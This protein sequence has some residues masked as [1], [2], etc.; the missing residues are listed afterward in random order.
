MR[1]QI[2]L[3]LIAIALASIFLSA[4]VLAD[5]LNRPADTL[6]AHDSAHVYGITPGETEWEI[7]T[8]QERF[9]SCVV[10]E[11]EVRCMT[12]E[13]LLETVLNYPYLVNIY[14]YDSLSSGIEAVSEYF[15]GLQEFINRDDALNTLANFLNNHTGYCTAS[16]TSEGA[17]QQLCASD[18]KAYIDTFTE[19]THNVSPL[20]IVVSTIRTPK[21]SPV[22]VFVG[23]TWADHQTSAT[24]QYT[25]QQQYLLTYPSIE[26]VSGV[27][28][29]Y[30]CH[31]Y[32]FYSTSSSNNY[33]MNDPSPYLE[34]GS[35]VHTTSTTVGNRVVYFDANDTP[36][37]SAIITTSGM[38][39]ILTSKWGCNAVFRHT[40]LDCPYVFS[41]GGYN[42]WRAS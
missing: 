12:T 8:T 42:Y 20:A 11:E 30:N 35:Y 10:T 27:D 17:F 18:L 9:A 24:Y 26:L 3:L 34:D 15:P 21:K 28:S 29:N 7:M 4:T 19:S 32:A 25:I 37:H 5:E 13:A 41:N 33:W 31:S 23:L 14:A 40:P 16:N 38:T 2:F 1:K 36:I 6:F 39:P 22:E